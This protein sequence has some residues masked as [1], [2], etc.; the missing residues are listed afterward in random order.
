MKLAEGL[1]RRSDLQSQIYHLN[2]RMTLNA[3]VQEGDEPAEDI[4]ELMATYES[5]MGQM[6]DIIRRIN[7]TNA[8]TPLDDGTL[9]SAIAKRD[10]L[11]SIIATYRE[12]CN[13]SSA[14]EN[15]YSRSEIKF[16]RLIN[17]AEMLKK[18]DRLSKEYRELDTKM[19][20]LNWTTELL[21]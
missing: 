14:R 2:R 16:V 17:I 15:R 12:L 4:D 9:A 18:V 8:F 5:V 3:K 1:L 19:Q 7:R 6:A 10:C 11:K 21:D 20:G 13:D